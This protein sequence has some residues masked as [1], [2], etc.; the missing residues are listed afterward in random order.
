MSDSVDLPAQALI[1]IQEKN[2]QIG[3][4]MAIGA[5]L[6]V[7]CILFARACRYDWENRHK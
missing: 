6:L 4:M 3:E 7:A 5:M 1:L 2:S